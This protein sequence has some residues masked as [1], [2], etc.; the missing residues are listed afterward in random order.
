MMSDPARPPRYRLSLH[1][2]RTGTMCHRSMEE[3][4][5]A[6]VSI[7]WVAT[8]WIRQRPVVIRLRI[9]TGAMFGLECRPGS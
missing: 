8:S 9:C 7:R 3:M 4:L 5:V 6:I 2:H 1:Q